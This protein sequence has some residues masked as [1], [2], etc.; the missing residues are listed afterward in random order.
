MLSTLV[1]GIVL[2]YGQALQNAGDS[3]EVVSTDLGPERCISGGALRTASNGTPAS[4]H[5]ET[6]MAC[7]SRC[8]RFHA[9]HKSGKK[10]A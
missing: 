3:V 10:Y 7:I 8:G 6:G 5:T 1:F 4:P 9:N 2:I